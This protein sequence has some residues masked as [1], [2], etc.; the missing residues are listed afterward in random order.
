MR[1]IT[2]VQNE[3]AKLKLAKTF[4]PSHSAFGTDNY[5]IIDAQIRV[6]E[7]ELTED[8]VDE[9]FDDD[10]RASALDAVTWREGDT[11]ESPSEGWEIF[12]PKAS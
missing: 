8:E 7:E 3:I 11:S 10:V 6:L 2:E 4:I 9:E 1:T 5:E 12:K